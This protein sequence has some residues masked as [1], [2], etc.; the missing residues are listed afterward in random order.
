MGWRIFGIVGLISFGIY[1]NTFIDL[2]TGQ[3][4]DPFIVGLVLILTA[5]EV[6]FGS[7]LMLLTG[8]NPYDKEKK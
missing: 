4:P 1:V 7:M 2:V 8:K 6:F 5:I 3:T